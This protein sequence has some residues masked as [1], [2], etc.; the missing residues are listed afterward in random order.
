RL[1][2]TPIFIVAAIIGIAE[3][4]ALASALNAP[5]Y[6]LLASLFCAGISLLVRTPT[7]RPGPLENDVFPLRCKKA[8][9]WLACIYA[10]LFAIARRLRLPRTFAAIGAIIFLGLPEIVL[11]AT[12][13]QNDLFTAGLSAAAIYFLLA[14]AQSGALRLLIPAAVAAG[15]AAGAKPTAWLL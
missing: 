3:L 11:Q 4:L 9:I 7:R 13:T 2:A 14:S 15:I 5:F 8:L 1:C 12:S 6:W 10:G